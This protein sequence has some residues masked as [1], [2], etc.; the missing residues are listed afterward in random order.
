MKQLK[1]PSSCRDT[2]RLLILRASFS[3][4]EKLATEVVSQQQATLY[5][6]G[7]WDDVESDFCGSK[8]ILRYNRD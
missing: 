3:M 6:L 1:N 4:A 8:S 2:E 5:E 7:A